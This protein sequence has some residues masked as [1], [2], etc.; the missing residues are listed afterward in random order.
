MSTTYGPQLPTP[1]DVDA[2]YARCLAAMN[3]A[4]PYPQ[5]EAALREWEQ[6]AETHYADRADPE[7]EAQAALYAEQEEPEAEI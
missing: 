6:T 3:S 7:P 2:S 4:T 5:Y 1:E